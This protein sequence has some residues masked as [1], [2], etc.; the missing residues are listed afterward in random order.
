MTPAKLTVPSLSIRNVG[1][2]DTLYICIQKYQVR[3]PV[4]LKLLSSGK[5]FKIAFKYVISATFQSL[6]IL[7]I[8]Y[9]SDST[10]YNVRS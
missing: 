3:I 4:G 8:M 10:L 9:A 5:L 2:T 6:D 7:M 1:A